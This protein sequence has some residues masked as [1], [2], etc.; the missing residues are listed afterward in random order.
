MPRSPRWRRGRPSGSTASPASERSELPTTV[1]TA[2]PG[3]G[4]S[5]SDG[6]VV[7]ASVL[8]RVFGI[9][10][11]RLEATVVLSPAELTGV[12]ARPRAAPLPV[13]STSVVRR[14][15][16]GSDLANAARYIDEGAAT[17]AAARNGRPP[18]R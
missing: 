16:I 17:L 5:L 7:E 11:L 9:R 4:R 15:A 10:L 13:R 2:V 12:A 18:K 8:G 1:V 6:V 3:A 14:G